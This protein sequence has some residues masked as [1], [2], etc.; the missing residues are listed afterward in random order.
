[1]SENCTCTKEKPNR[2]CR[3]HPDAISGEQ[4][5]GYPAGDIQEYTCPNCGLYFEVELPQ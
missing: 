3:V 4:R 2:N 5:D 1:M